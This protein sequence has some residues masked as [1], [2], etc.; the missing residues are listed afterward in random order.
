MWMHF[1]FWKVVM[2]VTYILKLCFRNQTK[3]SSL[4]FSSDFV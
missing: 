2:T 4:Y 1:I 3:E